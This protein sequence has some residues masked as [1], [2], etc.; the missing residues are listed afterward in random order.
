M[1]C[2]GGRRRG[3]RL[4][5]VRRL[6]A[7]FGNKKWKQAEREGDKNEKATSGKDGRVDDDFGCSCGNGGAPRGAG[8]S[9][10]DR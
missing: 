8:R 3:H 5:N 10:S 4:R 7:F 2:F 9:G 6:I 1:T